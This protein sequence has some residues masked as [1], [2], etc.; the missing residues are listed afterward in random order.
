MFFV[1][2]KW[3]LALTAMQIMAKI[4]EIKCSKLTLET[5]VR[6]EI[7]SKLTVKTPEQR[8]GVVLVSLLVT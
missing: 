8:S 7:C 5:R 3:K 2:R 1:I 4:A 6:C